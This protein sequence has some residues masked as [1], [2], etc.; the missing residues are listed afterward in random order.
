MQALSK[1]WYERSTDRTRTGNRKIILQKTHYLTIKTDQLIAYNEYSGKVVQLKR[2]SPFRFSN[3]YWTG[4]QVGKKQLFQV[5]NILPNK[6]RMLKIDA[7]DSSFIIEK[8]K[9]YN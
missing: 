2:N 3:K 9:K 4:I 6:F 5:R 8:S 1:K 7:E